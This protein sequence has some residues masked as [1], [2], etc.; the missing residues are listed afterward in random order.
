V[1]LAGVAALGVA[2]ASG[3]CT[4]P[5]DDDTERALQRSVVDA[6]RRELRDP[7]GQP[8]DQI[9]TRRGSI[10]DLHIPP[11][12]F[13]AEELARM[14]GPDSYDPSDP[15]VA[16][17]GL[18]LLGGHPRTVMV[19]LERAM[20]S[21]VSNNLEFQFASLAPAIAQ[22][23]VTQAEA[24][25]DWVLF[26][27]VERSWLNDQ[28][29]STGALLSRNA[30][31]VI[32]SRAGVR[33]ALGNG[34]AFSIQQDITYTRVRQNG[35]SPRGSQSTSLNWSFQ[36]DQPLMRDFGSD[37]AQSQVR[38]AR[39]AERSQIAQLEGRLIEL[40]AQVERTYWQ[41]WQAYHDVMILQRL[42]ER[43]ETIATKMEARG[44]GVNPANIANA[45]SRVI[46]REANVL[47]A[48]NA[49]HT[50]SDTLKRLMNDP[51]LP[52][53]SEILILPVDRPID[54][55]IT[56]NL[57]EALFTA[58]ERRP[59][60]AQSILS[61]DDTSIRQL[62]AAN[63][64]MPQLD[65][66]LQARS[67]ALERGTGD[68]FETAADT[69][70]PSY[71]AGLFFEQPIGNRDAEAVYARRRLE[72]SQ[73]IISYQNTIQAITNEVKT[74]LRNVGTN[75]QLIIKTHLARVAASEVLRSLTLQG[76]LIQDVSPER[77]D[78]EL[79]RQ[80]AL[81]QAERAE[82]ESLVAYNVAVAE[83]FA[84]QGTALDRNR[85]EFL[86]PD[87]AESLHWPYMPTET[88]G[89]AREWWQR[90]TADW[91]DDGQ[92]QGS[93]TPAEPTTPTD[94]AVPPP[95]GP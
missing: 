25:F 3:G 95:T 64:R 37:V 81:A 43:G 35:T 12:R 84:A 26:A 13:F 68:A 52:V 14:A 17:L 79:G 39:N 51:S 54:E 42:V 76:E 87:V 82:I 67:N 31:E 18:D 46:E 65:L 78:L 23:Q 93:P 24:A 58:I 30:R 53:G 90:H 1:R 28:N 66:R 16:P 77:L 21:A 74:A 73:A 91:D 4:T 7:L 80:E 19:S 2:L 32:A 29:L 41:L 60:V 69:T 63:Q 11:E 27:S 34:A 38:L 85:I 72:R 49:L 61:I 44:F 36:Y 8:A 6:V 22:A 5:F 47:R 50:L 70:F 75:Y 9:T 86:V 48:Q 59:E 88:A 15:R 89:Y 40:T 62:V 10:E 83:W 33:R 45:R 56:Y 92:D 94:P 57:G 55:P 71:V 20:R